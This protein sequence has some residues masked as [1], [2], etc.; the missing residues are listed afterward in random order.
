VVI[1][2]IRGKKLTVGITMQERNMDTFRWVISG[3]VSIFTAIFLEYFLKFRPGMAEKY[4]L[5][6]DCQR[7]S[8]RLHDTIKEIFK[9]INEVKKMQMVILEKLAEKENR[10]SG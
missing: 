6:S 3:L 4:V 2:D 5:K 7:D 8:D 1:V 9:E 10:K